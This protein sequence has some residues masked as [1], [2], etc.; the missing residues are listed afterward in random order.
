MYNNNVLN[1]DN[2]IVGMTTSFAIGILF[3]PF[4]RGL[5]YLILWFIIWEIMIFMIYKN[6]YNV[7][8]RFMYVI[9]SLLGFYIGRLTIGDDD[10]FN[11]EK[12]FFIK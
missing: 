2:I 8:N 5:L 3:A 9:S 11:N 4:S 10:I 1:F 7:Y 6:E 12:K